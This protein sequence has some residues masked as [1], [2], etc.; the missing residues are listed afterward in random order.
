MSAASK[1]YLTFSDEAL[2]MRICR[3]DEFAFR[4]LYDRYAKKLQRYFFRMLYQDIE[5]ANDQTQELFI[6]VYQ[7]ATLFDSSQTF[8]T[9]LYSIAN[10]QCKNYYRSQS[11]KPE[12]VSLEEDLAIFSFPEIEEQSKNMAVFQKALNQAL[13]QLPESQRNLFVLRYQ[14]AFTIQEIAEITATAEGTIKS[15]LHRILK[16]LSKALAPFHPKNIES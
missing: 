15:G 7:K 5:I 2:M 4:V 3:K 10:N 14:E 8:S 6:K 13:H 12:S 16:K 1:K 11:R 9:W